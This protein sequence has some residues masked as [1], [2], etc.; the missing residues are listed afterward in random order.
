MSPV[1]RI[2]F[3]ALASVLLVLGFVKTAETFDPIVSGRGARGTS[4]GSFGGATVA[5]W[6]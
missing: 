2:L 1:Q 6:F 5:R 4:T 3:G